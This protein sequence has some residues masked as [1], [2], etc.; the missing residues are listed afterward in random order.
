MAMSMLFV[1]LPHLPQEDYNV[2][3]IELRLDLFP[4]LDTVALQSF[5]NSSSF[6]IMF[7]FRGGA[8]D[9]ILKC[10]QL[11]PDYFDLEYDRPQD[12]LS[13]TII[14]HPETKFIIS[15]HNFIET[16]EDLEGIYWEMKKI[17]AHGYK[18][19]CLATSTND[20]LRMLLL[21][22]KYPDLS[23]ICMGEN[24][25]FARVLG[26]VV[27]NLI[28]YA[29]AGEKTAPGQLTVQ[30]MQDIYRYRALNQETHI[31]GLIGD[32]IDMSIGHLYH[33]EVFQTRGINAVYVKMSVKQEE[34]LCFFSLAERLGFKGLSVTMPLKEL[35]IPESGAINTLRFER[36][37]KIGINTDG[38]GALDAIEK[39]C[40]VKGKIILILGAGGAAYAIAL[41]AMARG[42][43]CWI[44]NR[45]EKKGELLAKVLGCHAGMPPDYDILINCAP[46][47]ILDVIRPRS[48]VMDIVYVPKVT[49]FIKRAIE[50]G[51]EIVYGEEMFFNQAKAQTEFWL[52]SSCGQRDFEGCS[53]QR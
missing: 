38:Q 33:N 24:G 31:Y 8:C 32:P 39:K 40:L 3:G 9:L 22:K 1:S 43:T 44:L 16:P 15:Y 12:F 17:A 2:D 26:P 48:L 52:G 27:G 34:L 18:I 35:V 14:S 11:K 13:S 4:R 19:A 37:K 25:Q 30:E 23:V 28:D 36:G 42:A 49:A 20:A 45:S 5:L 50:Q 41:E 6:P 53:S 46:I 51:C 29:C 10:L 7:T 21:S 47:A